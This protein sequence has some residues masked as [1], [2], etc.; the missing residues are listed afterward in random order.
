MKKLQVKLFQTLLLTST[1]PLM[2]VGLITLAFLGKMAVNDAEQRINSA[3][4][5]ALNTYQNVSD[6]LKF[7]V[8]DQNRRIFSLLADDQI[9]LLKNEYAKVTAKNNLDFFVVTDNSGKVLVSMSSPQF[10]GADYSRD[11]FV[12]KALR[13]Q[14]YVST[15]VLGESDLAK[16]GLLEKSRISGIA[17][18][19]GLVLKASMPV[20]NSNEILVGTMTAGYLLNN[21]NSVIV[22]KISRG[23]DLVS[24]VFLG[25]T[26]VCSNLPLAKIPV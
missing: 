7:T 17:P 5:L 19:Q 1:L 23:T 4:K 20:F 16:L 26:R 6:N 3:V 9:D 15:E 10:E 25:N 11:F 18:V 22:D 24:T 14:I 8:R 12:R 21:N 2:I 13:G